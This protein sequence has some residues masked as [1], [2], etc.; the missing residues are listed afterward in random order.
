MGRPRGSRIQR[1]V[2]N[3][4]RIGGHASLASFS[5]LISVLFPIFAV[6][7]PKSLVILISAAGIVGL[8]QAARLKAWKQLFPPTLTVLM[9]SILA[10][11]F[12][13]A[14]AT[15]YGLNSVVLWLRL[16]ALTMFGFGTL[17]LF[18][19]LEPN[20]RYRIQSALVL[21]ICLSLVQFW[22]AYVVGHVAGVTLSGKQ[23]A[24]PLGALTAGQSII[25]IVIG[26]AAGILLARR[27]RLAV[28]LLYAATIATF[29]PLSSNFAILTLL[30]GAVGMVWAV[31]FRRVGLRILSAMLAVFILA[32]PFTP[33]TAIRDSWSNPMLH[34]WLNQLDPANKIG[35]SIHHRL[36]IWEFTIQ[37]AREHPYL[38]WGLD[39]SRQIPGGMEITSLNA[40]IMPLHPH[41]SVLQIWLE[42]VAPGVILFAC[43][44]S[45]MFL[46]GLPRRES[47]HLIISHVATLLPAL[48]I[49]FLAF[50]IWQNWWYS[51]LWMVGIFA[52]TLMDATGEK[53]S[54]KVR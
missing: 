54:E 49:A 32:I 14:I 35:P 2:L 21:G 45:Y 44:V 26:V 36:Q 31:A 17:W 33:S 4:F 50:G 1:V 10:W 25:A 16:C 29:V 41:N 27:R 18:R 30:I 52:S 38:G 24:D 13:R 39:A 9:G 12:F 42:L 22:L 43:L 37:R 51:A 20:E 28:I 6:A 3:F 34:V 11:M 40:N 5:A 23:L 48:S 7:A 46:T 53:T 47:T 15:E 8:V 19:S